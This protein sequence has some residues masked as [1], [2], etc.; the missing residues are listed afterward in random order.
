MNLNEIR[1]MINRVDYEIVKLLNERLELALRTK[2]LKPQII[3]IEREKEVIENVEGIQLRLV[4]KKFSKKLFQS[5]I[6]ECRSIQ[7][8]DRKLVGFHGEHGSDG[9][10]AASRYS[11]EFVPVPCLQ[12]ADV[13]ESINN[14]YFDYGILPVENSI[15]GGVSEVDDLLI[16]NDLYICGEIR[17]PLNYAVLTLPE[18]DY[19]GIKEVYSHPQVLS[20]CHGFITRNNLEARPYYNAAAAARMI[21]ETKPR[22][23]AVI[24][25]PLCAELHNLVIIKENIEDDASGFTRFLLLSKTGCPVDG[26]KCSI[27][28]STR[29]KFGGL[30]TILKMFNDANIDLARF[31]SRPSPLEKGNFVF[32]LDFLG[33]EK[34]E[35]VIKTLKAVEKR[36]TMF[37]MLGFYN[38]MEA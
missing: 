15:E 20:H 25:S 23:A 1:E 9:E 33:S 10:L 2:K 16:E 27:I 6:M 8:E 35:K 5:I 13:V 36:A 21:A 34:D 7:M 32:I 28:F 30:Y 24:A 14:D 29:D 17:Q 37:K 4:S 31:E 11:S 22:A 3:D 26:N 12:M 19:R 38:E 18:N